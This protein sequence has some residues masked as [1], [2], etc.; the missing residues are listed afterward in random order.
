MI[1]KKIGFLDNGERLTETDR[2]IKLYQKALKLKEEDC[3]LCLLQMKSILE[4]LS[5]S[6][7][8]K[9]ISPDSSNFTLDD[10]IN[11]IIIQVRIPKVVAI[12]IRT[13]QIICS[14]SDLNNTDCNEVGVGLESLKVVIDWYVGT[15]IDDLDSSIEL[16]NK[17]LEDN[18][19][20]YNSRQTK[21]KRKL[22]TGSFAGLDDFDRVTGD[23]GLIL[24]KQIRLTSQKSFEHTVCVGPTGSGKTAS[25]FIPNLLSLPNSSIVVSDPK[26]E[27][28]EKTAAENIAQGKD[29][30]VFNPYYK[31]TMKY[32]PLS[33]C[34][35][36]Y[37][38]REL[39]QVLLTNGNSSIEALTGSK[40]N[41]SEWINM[42]VPLLTAFL[43]FV[44]DLTPP[45]NTISY[46]LDLITENDMD[47]LEYLISTDSDDIWDRAAY[48][49]FKIF[50]QS[51]GSE[52][53]A[54]SI[55]T[56]LAAN[57][58]I[59]AD[60]L[61]Q[62]ATSAN[63]IIP[64]KL[65]ERPTVLYVNVPEHKSAALAPLMAP[66]YTQLMEHLIENDNDQPVYFLLD[67]FANIGIIPNIDRALATFRSRNIS[68][69]IGIQ[70]LNQLQQ[71]YGEKKTNSI[72]DNLKT[73]IILPGLS[74][75]SA[76]YFSKLCGFHEIITVNK[77]FQFGTNKSVSFNSLPQKRELLTAAEVRRL[78]DETMLIIIDNLNPFRDNQYRYYYDIDMI[79]KTFKEMNL[80]DFLLEQNGGS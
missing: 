80:E 28:F 32:N 25:F 2:L 46:A 9:E 49:Q 54:A 17:K 79:D 29:V 66:F 1:E 30:L 27:L 57:L 63:N 37:E 60:P 48:K 75:D 76:D 12:H 7:F 62:N 42:S 45:K 35:D 67:E 36:V 8:K 13:V 73:K 61:I 44:K 26:G 24:G 71:I 55:K 39:A 56:V 3:D 14:D 40:A 51:G 34:N 21:T 5:T 50:K 68:I 33:L 18:S 22:A 74:Y 38:V 53:T 77:S 16:R 41:D 70:S 43:L 20:G 69:S 6:M 31:N 58:Q 72:I 52:G 11:T 64:Q 15:D 59:F 65:R 47:E 10:I 19:S 78:E 4:H 23:D